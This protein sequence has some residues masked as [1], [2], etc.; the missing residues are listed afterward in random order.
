[1]KSPLEVLQIVTTVFDRL[2]IE[3]VIVGSF[4]SSRRGVQRTTG[5]VDILANLTHAKVRSFVAALETEFYLD[6]TT[7][8]EAIS[9]RRS[10]NAIH[11]D[12][13]FKVDVFIPA[14][15]FAGW[16]LRRRIAEPIADNSPAEICFATA[17]DVLVAKLRWFRAGGEVSSVQWNDIRG[18]CQ[19][20][21]K[22]LD[23]SYIR[24]WPVKLCV[25]ELLEK[26]LQ[27]AE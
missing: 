8:H 17:E 16:Q 27:E 6:E 26:V 11:L 9:R 4:A 20:N 23:W 5:D 13:V 14:D 19:V 12:S 21:R 25:T 7:V 24:D 2:E 1:M 3:Y 15:E 22:Y 18:I 10:F